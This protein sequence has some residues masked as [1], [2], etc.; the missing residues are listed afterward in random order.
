MPSTFEFTPS[1]STVTTTIFEFTSFTSSLIP[2]TLV[3]TLT[4]TSLRS[5]TSFITSS[6]LEFKSSTA[7]FILRKWPFIIANSFTWAS[8][9]PWIFVL[10]VK[11]EFNTIEFLTSKLMFFNA[12]V[13]KVVNPNPLTIISPSSQILWNSGLDRFL[14]SKSWIKVF[15]HFR[16]LI[17]YAAILVSVG[18]DFLF[19][20]FFGGGSVVKFMISTMIK[21]T[22]KTLLSVLFWPGG[23]NVSCCALLSTPSLTNLSISTF[24]LRNSL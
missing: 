12:F 11:I 5:S 22:S 16:A 4:T 6:N 18:S 2:S 19:H 9:V 17:T 20:P 3:F 24:L 8:S 10:Y 1:T 21:V 23:S 15:L 7:T 14:G 13:S